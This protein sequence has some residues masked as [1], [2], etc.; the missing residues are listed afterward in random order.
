MD[1]KTEINNAFVAA[2]KKQL[3]ANGGS[4]WG[5]RDSLA[6]IESIC[7]AAYLGDAPEGFDGVRE[8][9][10]ALVNPS[11]FRQSLEAKGLVKASV[12]GTRSKKVD[13]LADITA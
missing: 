11:A 4:G 10:L 8:R 9:V 1:T 3:Q 13:L 7:D 5:G 6:V 2:V 12:P